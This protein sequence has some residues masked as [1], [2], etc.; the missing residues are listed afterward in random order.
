MQPTDRPS[1]W[2]RSR[3]SRAFVGNFAASGPNAKGNPLG[4]SMSGDVDLTFR[5]RARGGSGTSIRRRRDPAMRLSA[6]ILALSIVTPCAARAQSE[7]RRKVQAAPLFEEGI[8]LGDKG[9]AAESLDKFEKAYGIYPSPNTLYNIARQEQVLGRKLQAMRHYRAA[10]RNKVLNPAAVEPARASVVEL[11]RALGRVRIAGPDGIRVEV[12]GAEYALPLDEPI[13]VDPG[14]VSVRGTYGGELLTASGN[15]VAGQTVTLTLV[16]SIPAATATAPPR[17]LPSPAALDA[18]PPYLDTVRLV[19]FVTIAVGLTGLGLG[20]AF[21]ASSRDARDQANPISDRLG[22]SAC[23]GSA[24]DPSCP[25]LQQLRG[26]QSSDANRAIGFYIAG[27]VLAAGGAA[28]VLWPRGAV[29]ASP[30]IHPNGG[31]ASLQGR[32]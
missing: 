12:G 15:A 10:L 17:A 22:R 2:T 26:T 6:A 23:A 18:H 1:S 8:R 7:D 11:E 21:A 20:V 28:L 29:T 3:L 9:Q 13:D 32:F 30:S 31:G 19:G 16:S 14:T 24:P 5:T 4:G 27:G 25:L